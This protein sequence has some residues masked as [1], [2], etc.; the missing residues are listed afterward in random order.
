[1]SMPLSS[2]GGRAHAEDAPMSHPV[3]T[4]ATL[5]ALGITLT[6]MPL[7]YLWLTMETPEAFERNMGGAAAC[8]TGLRSVMPSMQP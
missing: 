6:T 2:R 5:V 7:G 3:R 4:F 8:V 1:M